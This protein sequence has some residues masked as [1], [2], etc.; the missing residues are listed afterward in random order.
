MAASGTREIKRRIRSVSNTQKI[1]KAL[2]TVSAVKMRKAQGRA[3]AGRPYAEA[4]VALLRRLSGL[5][6]EQHPLLRKKDTGLQLL[7]IF[8][9]DKGLTGGLMTNLSRKVLEVIEDQKKSKG[10]KTE[11]RAIGHEAENFARRAGLNVIKAERSERIDLR[12]ARTLKDELVAAYVDGPY[13]KILLG[14]MQFV[15]TLKQRPYVRGILPI[16]EEK[17]IDVEE[18]AV[19]VTADQAIGRNKPT[20]VIVPAAPL[21]TETHD[22]EPSPTALLNELIP[23]LVTML[24]YHVFAESAASEHSAR[25]LAMKN[26]YDNATDLIGELTQTFNKLRQ[27]SITAS[28]AEISGGVAALETT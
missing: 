26:A 28:L 14:Y 6:E 15:S 18:L 3:L 5:T 27:E 20:S 12:R 22:L 17:I 4:A 9:P 25:M 23:D 11:V 24:L 16:T 21:S 7:V 1:T 13:D 19:K 8:S 2:Q 10:R